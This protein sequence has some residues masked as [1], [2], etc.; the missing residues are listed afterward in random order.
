MKLNLVCGA[1]LLNLY[2]ETLMMDDKEKDLKASVRKEIFWRLR[3]YD[4][5][6]SEN[7]DILYDKCGEN[8]LNKLA[9]IMGG[10]L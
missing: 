7:I 5:Q 4:Q 8:V 1:D 2:L 9:E 10:E 3:V 6:V